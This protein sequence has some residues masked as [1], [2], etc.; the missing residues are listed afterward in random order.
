MVVTGVPPIE[1]VIAARV[2]HDRGTRLVDDHDLA[3][4]LPAPPSLLGAV[5]VATSD[6][7][8]VGIGNV[9]LVPVP[10]AITIPFWVSVQATV[11]VASGSGSV[12][13]AVTVIVPSSAVPRELTIW[14]VGATSFTTIDV[15]AEVVF[16]PSDTDTWMS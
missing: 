1:I 10:V 11:S 15:P 16:T 2:D 5:A 3:L 4:S 6:A 9:K 13:T 7:E 8:R 12:T 14:T